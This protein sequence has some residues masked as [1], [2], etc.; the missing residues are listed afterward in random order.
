[1]ISNGGVEMGGKFF[2]SMASV[3]GT[4]RVRILFYFYFYFLYFQFGFKALGRL[5]LVFV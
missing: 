1:V 3:H 2:A 5:L 4:F